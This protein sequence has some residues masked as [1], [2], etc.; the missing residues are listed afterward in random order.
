MLLVFLGTILLLCSRWQQH[1]KIPENKTRFTLC[2][3]TQFLEV[4]VGEV[5]MQVSCSHFLTTKEEEKPS[6]DY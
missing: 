2:P 1:H 4:K 6:N 5:K 3:N